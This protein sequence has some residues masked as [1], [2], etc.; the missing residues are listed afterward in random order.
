MRQPAPV[1]SASVAAAVSSP[2]VKSG[3]FECPY[4]AN[5]RPPALLSSSPEKSSSTPST[6]LGYRSSTSSSGAPTTRDK[7]ILTAPRNTIE[8][9]CR[10]P[11]RYWAARPPA[12]WHIGIAPR[13][14]PQRFISPTDH[15][16]EVCVGRGRSG[17]RSCE[18]L[19]VETMELSV[20][21]GNC[22]SAAAISAWL[23]SVEETP[24]SPH[25][26]GQA[27]AAAS[28]APEDSAPPGKAEAGVSEASAMISPMSTI[29]SATGTVGRRWSARDTAK[30][31]IAV[32]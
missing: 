21:S 12:P 11:N 2:T 24:R 30:Q 14:Q 28:C 23:T 3:S 20:V 25:V 1:L 18:S 6:E 15:A 4:P 9:P 31:Q 27:V 22:G 8:Q 5:A 17:K 7:P 16:S 32:R 29:S 13:R 26:T 10:A 19:Q